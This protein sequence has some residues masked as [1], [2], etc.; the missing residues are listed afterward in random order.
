MFYDPFLY[1]TQL[2][3]DFARNL[4]LYNIKNKY[5][6]SRLSLNGYFVLLGWIL[7]LSPFSKVFFD[8]HVCPSL[9]ESLTWQVFF[10]HSL[11]LSPSRRKSQLE[12]EGVLVVLHRLAGHSSSFCQI[13]PGKSLGVSRWR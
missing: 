1:I 12:E 6:R 11:P 3:L 9:N 5:T 13:Y 4:L 8:V 2:I 7:F 10:S